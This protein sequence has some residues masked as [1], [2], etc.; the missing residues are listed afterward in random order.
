[1]NKVKPMQKR[2]PDEK[3]FTLIEVI[4]T[5]VL[6]AITA[7]LAG[8]WIVS[9]A[10]GY[11]FAKMNTKTAQNGQLAMARL[12]KEFIA[13]KSVTSSSGTGITYHRT[14]AL[15]GDV[16]ATVSLSLSGSVLQLDVGTGANTLTDGVSSFALQYC[17]VNNLCGVGWLPSS[18]SILITLT[19][20]G[21]SNT[22]LIQRVAPRNL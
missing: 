11:V 18:K 12:E 21:A 17:D 5:L 9:V 15:L 20:T 10:N 7:S 8:M 19:L 1:M 4:V 3:G 6:V 14:D 13:I 2:K 22:S 16:L